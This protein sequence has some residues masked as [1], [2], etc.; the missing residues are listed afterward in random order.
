MDRL[1]T[2][3]FYDNLASSWDETR[4]EFTSTIFAEIVS[5]LDKTRPLLILDFG[6]GTGLL[7]KYLHENLPSAKIDG[8]DISSEMVARARMSCP[9][10][11]FYAGG[12]FSTRLPHYD[13]VIAKDVFNHIDDIPKTI[14]RLDGLLNDEGT[15]VVANRERDAS[16]RSSI[17][18]T[19]NSLHYRASTHTYSFQPTEEEVDS[20]LRSLSGFDDRQKDMI[21]VRLATPSEYYIVDA[22]KNP[23]VIS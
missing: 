5:L 19:L 18:R 6:C 13:V 11:T 1:P 22:R 14:L 9:N 21:R 17:R 4:P 3:E 16:V 10:C 7:S 15:I 2:K 8:I 23:R 12:I 20:F